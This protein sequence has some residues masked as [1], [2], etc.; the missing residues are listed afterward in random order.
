MSSGVIKCQEIEWN[1]PEKGGNPL[2]SDEAGRTSKR[3][4]RGEK[5]RMQCAAKAMQSRGS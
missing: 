2:N 5:S 4:R 3:I 1:R